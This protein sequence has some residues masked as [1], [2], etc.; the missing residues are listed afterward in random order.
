MK[1]ETLPPVTTGNHTTAK[2]IQLLAGS[3]SKPR[4]IPLILLPAK[5]MMLLLILL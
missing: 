2:Q 1:S 4:F 3:G 5:A